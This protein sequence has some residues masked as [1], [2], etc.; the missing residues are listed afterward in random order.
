NPRSKLQ[1]YGPTR[2]KAVSCSLLKDGG[3]LSPSPWRTDIC[4][5]HNI[6]PKTVAA[7]QSSALECEQS[8]ESGLPLCMPRR[9]FGCDPYAALRAPIPR[10][11]SHHSAIQLE[12]F[13]MK[14]SA[15]LACAAGLLFAGSVLTVRAADEPMPSV[16]QMAPTFTL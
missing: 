13:P 10:P 4:P 14:K 7:I 1:H 6:P 2:G 3:R 12:V 9:Q 15:L 8:R 5:P 11:R 16:G